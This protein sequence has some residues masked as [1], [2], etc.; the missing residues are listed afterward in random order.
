MLRAVKN[1]FKDTNHAMNK[2]NKEFEQL[3]Q[4][5]Q[6]RAADIKKS[7]NRKSSLFNQRKKE[8]SKQFDIIRNK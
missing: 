6:Q 1:L 3:S 8:K 4:D 5:N 7:L 2:L